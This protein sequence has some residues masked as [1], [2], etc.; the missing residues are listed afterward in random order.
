M[1]LLKSIKTSDPDTCSS[2][3]KY[4]HEYLNM[5]DRWIKDYSTGAVPGRVS[6][7]VKYLADTDDN[8]GPFE[9]SLLSGN[10]MAEIH[11]VTPETVGKPMSSLKRNTI[12]QRID[13]EIPDK[14]YCNMKQLQREAEL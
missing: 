7:L 14:K 4:W 8:T 2:L 1:P 10:E 12:I 11:G 9:V 5:A 3:L 6:R 13:D